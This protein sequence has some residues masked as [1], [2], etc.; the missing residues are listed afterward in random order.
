[1]LYKINNEK[2]GN[3]NKTLINEMKKLDNSELND[4]MNMARELMVMNGKMTFKPGMKVFMVQKTKKT[5]GT[6]RRVLQKNVVVDMDNGR[7]YRVPMS[8][9]EAA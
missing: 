3:M 5:P 1:L 7:S 4:V 9:L 8:M 6:V 2:R